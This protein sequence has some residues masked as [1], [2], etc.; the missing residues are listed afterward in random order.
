MIAVDTSRLGGA[1]VC[2]KPRCG[3]VV[4]ESDGAG[5]ALGWFLVHAYKSLLSTFDSQ[6]CVN[7]LFVM[8]EAK[9]NRNL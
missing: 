9:L 7:G 3:W 5:A 8:P 6:S 2:Y 4:Q 1:C